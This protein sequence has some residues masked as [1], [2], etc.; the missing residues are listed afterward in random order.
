[1]MVLETLLIKAILKWT[2]V[3]KAELIFR[4][5]IS[6]GEISISKYELNAFDYH[7][8]GIDLRDVDQVSI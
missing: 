7:V 3:R 2:V 1:M 4:G 6:D 5:L 8:V